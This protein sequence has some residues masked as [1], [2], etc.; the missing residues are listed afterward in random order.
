MWTHLPDTR[1]GLLVDSADFEYDKDPT[2]WDN[3]NED[4]LKKYLIPIPSSGNKGGVRNY[5]GGVAG[6]TGLGKSTI[7]KL[8]QTEDFPAPV[9]LAERA[10]GWKSTD[11][12]EWIK[13]RP[14]TQIPTQCNLEREVA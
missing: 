6:L 5:N 3:R 8:I 10:V 13:N 11:V 2:N 7:Y 14:Y 1:L 12:V 4:L 9:R